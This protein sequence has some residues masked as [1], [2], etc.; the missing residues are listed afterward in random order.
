M[1][2]GRAMQ[3]YSVAA[4]DYALDVLLAV[5]EMPDQ[6]VSEIARRLGGSKQRIFRMLRTLETRGLLVRD[7]T[8]KGYRLGFLALTLGTAAQE[9]NDLARLA[10]PLIH[11]LTEATRETVQLRIRD[12]GETV[13]IAKSEPQRDV[14]VNATVGRRSPLHVGSSKMFLAYMP[15]EEAER[16][17]AVGLRRFTPNTITDPNRLRA[18]L[19]A[20]RAAG[21]CVSRG[22]MS[23]DLVSITAPVFDAG[24]RLSATINVAAPAARVTEERA[25]QIVLLA[26]GT[27]QQLSQL[28]GHYRAT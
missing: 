9:Q 13:C 11:A 8:S 1:D 20:I 7:A 18:R 26:K 25:A 16:I 5:A 28:L 24:G 19:A 27:A 2:E 22:E 23:I 3:S 15:Q 10:S 14:R 21:H 6:G 17:I 4:V 12:G